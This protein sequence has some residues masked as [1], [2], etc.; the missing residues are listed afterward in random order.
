MIRWF[1]VIQNIIAC[2]FSPSLPFLGFH[3]P[4]FAYFVELNDA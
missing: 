4:L 3:T 1:N 2:Q